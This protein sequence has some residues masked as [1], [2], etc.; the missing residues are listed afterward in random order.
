GL[1]SSSSAVVNADGTVN[2]ILGSVDIGGTRA[3]LAMQLA[4]ALGLRADDIKPQVVDTDSVGWTAVTAGSRTTFAGGWVAYEL[5]QEIRKRLTERAARI[6]DVD[7]EQVTYQDDGT[8]TGP[9]DD[10]GKPRRFTFKE[11][12]GKL[13]QTGGLIA[14]STSVTKNTQGPAYA[15]H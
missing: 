4:E 10:E 14:V 3:S 15:G 2:L 1:E 12:A 6:W 8:V 11:I 9:D 5:G 13:Q 7:I